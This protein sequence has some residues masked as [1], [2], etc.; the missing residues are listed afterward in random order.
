MGSGGAQSVRSILEADH[1]VVD[2]AHQSGFAPQPAPDHAL[3]PKVE[4]GLIHVLLNMT[5]VPKRPEISIKEF[6]QALDL[7]VIGEI[8]F[9]SESFGQ[10][11][12]NG[13]MLEEVNSKSEAALAFRDIALA[14][15]HRRETRVEKKASP[16]AGLGPL[17]EKLKIKR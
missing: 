6:E 5:G 11:S 7:K 4:L 10:A 16:L 9:D 17:L 2:V 15:T 12:N 13:Q 8:K 1:E 3:E 14:I